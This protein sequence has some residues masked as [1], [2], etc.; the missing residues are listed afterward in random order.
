MSNVAFLSN[1]TYILNPYNEADHIT[2]GINK[3]PDISNG[4]LNL[5]DYITGSGVNQ[6]VRLYMIN[7]SESY[8]NLNYFNIPSPMDKMYLAYGDFNFTFQNNYTTDHEIEGDD[9]LHLDS[10]NLIKAPFNDLFSQVGFDSSLNLTIV[11]LNNLTDGNGVSSYFILNSTSGGIVNLTIDASFTNTFFNDNWGLITNDPFDGTNVLGF[12]LTLL[13][14]VSMDANLTI[15]MKYF[16]DN[17]TTYWKNVTNSV[18]LNSTLGPHYIDEKIINENL[19]LIRDSYYNLSKWANFT[20]TYSFDAELGNSGLGIDF[21]DEYNG[22]QTAIVILEEDTHNYVLKLEDTSEVDYVGVYNNLSTYQPNGTIEFWYKT[23]NATKLNFIELFGDNGSIQNIFINNSQ[24]YYFNST[25]NGTLIPNVNNPV[26][27]E[28]THIRIDFECTNGNYL[29]LGEKQ[30]RINI[31]GSDSGVLNFRGINNNNTKFG[32]LGFR[33]NITN[34]GINILQHIDAIGYSW[35]VSY[36]IGDNLNRVG[37]VNES[38]VC[39]IQFIMNNTNSQT[40]NSTIYDFSLES[41]YGIET[42][43]TNESYVALEFDL[44]GMNSTVNGIYAWIRTRNITQAQNAE[45]NISLYKANGTITRSQ[46]DS[47]DIEPL[48]NELIDSIIVKNYN[49]D[50]Q[51]HFKFDSSKTANLTLYNYFIVIKS[52]TSIP[53]Y[54]LVNFPESQHGDSVIDHQLKITNDNGTS[55]QNAIHALTSTRLDASSFKI[56]VTRG[57]KASDFKIDNEI[58]LM[59]ENIS[60]YGIYNITYTNSSNLEWGIGRWKQHYFIDAIVNNSNQNF[61]VNLT[62]NSSITDGLLF[63]VSYFVKVYRVENATATYNVTY[64]GIPQ[65]TLNYTLN[66]TSSKFSNWNFSSFTYIYPNYYTAFNLTTP[67]PYYD[68]VLSDTDGESIFIENYLYDHINVTT[69]I[70]NLS[71]TVKYSGSY[72]LNLTS[73]NILIHTMHSYINFNGK[74]WET[75]GFMFGDNISVS[76]D[77]QDHNNQAPNSGIAEVLLFFPNGTRYKYHNLTS[78]NSTTE[79]SILSYAFEDR[80]ILNL[81]DSLPLLGKYKLGYFWTN[82]SILGCNITNIYL[83]TYDISMKNVTYLPNLLGG[84]NI[85]SG[86]VNPQVHENYTLLIGSVN[87]TT[88]I[89]NTEF[90]P[91]NKSFN[92]LDGKM[93]L[94]YFGETLEIYLQ[95]ILQNETILNPEEIIT[96]KSKIQN[97]HPILDLNIKIHIKL[98][99]LANEEWIIAE[100]YSNTQLLKTRGAVGDTYEFNVNLTMPKLYSNQTW[101]GVNSPVRKSGAKT[102]ASVYIEDL[103]AGVEEMDDHTFYSLLINQTEDKF[104]GYIIEFKETN[105]VTQE[106]EQSALMKYFE[107]EK[108]IY[109]PN[110]TTFIINIYDKNY[111]SSYNQF[112]EHFQL[113]ID[114]EFSNIVIDPATPLNGKSFNVTS[115][116]ITEFGNPLDNKKITIQHNISGIWENISSQF[117]NLNGTTNFEI[118]TSLLNIVNETLGLRLIWAGDTYV[119]NQT[120]NFTVNIIIQINSISIAVNQEG[121]LLH[122]DTSSTLTFTIKNI[123][124]SNLKILEVDFNLSINLNYE[125]KALNYLLFDYF[126]PGDSID[127]LIEIQVPNLGNNEINITITI[128]GQNL[129]SNELVTI[130]KL[131]TVTILDRPLLDYLIDYFMFLIL[132]LIG[133]VWIFAYIY[134]KRINKK[135]ELPIKEP[136][137]RRPRKGKYVKVS[138][139]KPRP[140]KPEE[141]RKKKSTPAKTPEKDVKKKE[142]DLKVVKKRTDLD[143][144]IEKD[145]EKKKKKK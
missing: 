6:T 112:L 32:K 7:E 105:V 11:D 96:F 14:N 123:G 31:D 86:T 114:S 48:S 110:K 5:T 145:L 138:E 58:T 135:I 121:F 53:L 8:D 1:V 85:L 103:L 23:S 102:I 55:W 132:G 116:L 56:N 76:L 20:G 40:F 142:I 83:S 47:I 77:I 134:L 82:G 15:L 81:N 144:L 69:N 28:W 35:N 62:W 125:I 127:I 34:D 24:W 111:I 25:N 38:N 126:A 57:Y 4:N 140:T 120:I 94:D 37:F 73:K 90:Y 141:K 44:R 115:D 91:I 39:F 95:S 107:R 131:V 78:P 9:A 65:W 92:Q 2:E 128:K 52:N 50:G 101:Y 41:I 26:S 93:T 75:N 13:L 97:M 104:E 117:T 98:V 137:T 80:I 36:S 129:I 16:Y 74:L 29:G 89:S 17:G 118:N 59:I 43:I 45:L 88:G 84:T 99:S 122:R 27:N 108:C 46:V 106:A 64:D 72:L 119:L 133:L 30:F 12:N 113:K 22:T 3:T 143:A 87:D 79:N 130:D 60:F 100:A 68:Q 10:V 51:T 124:N 21:V 63:N 136:V 49:G 33:T 42:P 19:N 139:L 71:D 18:F 66:L 70:V 61:Q 54:S 67:A 109:L